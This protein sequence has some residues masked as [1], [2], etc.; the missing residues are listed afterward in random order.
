[1][2]A[3]ITG[4]GWVNSTGMG[5]GREHRRFEMT[6]GRLPGITRPAIFE[7]PCQRFGRMDRFSRLGLAA[8]AFALKDAGLEKWTRKRDIGIIASTVYGCLATDVDYFDT[9][10]PQEGRLARPNLLA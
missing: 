3:L 7:K 10:I 1:M 9:V 6:A 2:K 4:I 8:I 5:C